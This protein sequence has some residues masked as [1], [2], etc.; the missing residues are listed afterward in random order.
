MVRATPAISPTQL[1][2]LKTL[3]PLDEKEERDENHDGQPDIQN[4]GHGASLGAVA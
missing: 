2:A 1:L 4:I 3:D